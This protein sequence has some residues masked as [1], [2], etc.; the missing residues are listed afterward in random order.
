ML[1][2]MHAGGR[3]PG[4][5]VLLSGMLLLTQAGCGVVRTAE[6]S[7]KVIYKGNP[8]PGGTVVFWPVGRGNPATSSIAEDG[9]Y[10]VRVPVGEVKISVNNEALRPKEKDGAAAKGAKGAGKGKPKTPPGMIMSPQEMMRK[11]AQGK[12]P[13]PDEPEAPAGKYVPIP[14]RFSDPEKSGLTYTV[15]SGAQEYDIRLD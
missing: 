12:M 3:I 2:V 6:V 5:F 15:K 7:G 10:W 14:A 4:G 11:G 9:R 8:L 1:S 13:E